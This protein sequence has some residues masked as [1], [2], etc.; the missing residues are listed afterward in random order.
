MQARKS[1]G[2]DQPDLSSTGFAAARKADQGPF[3]LD[4]VVNED[5]GRGNPGPRNL[6]CGRAEDRNHFSHGLTRTED[7]SW[8]KGPDKGRKIGD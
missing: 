2:S 7:A 5:P 8:T 4:P 6:G 1:H 3:G